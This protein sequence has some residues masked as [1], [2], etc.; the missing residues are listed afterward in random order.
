MRA[1]DGGRTQE[2][3]TLA[4]ISND[5]KILAG[6][7]QSAFLVA[8]QINREGETGKEPPKLAN[9]AGSDALGQ[10][11]DVVLTMRKEAHNVGTAFSVEGNRHGEEVK[12]YTTFDPNSGTF[13]EVDKDYLEELKLLAEERL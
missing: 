2:W 13:D 9:L 10:D 1:D 7:A 5:L 8:S 12:F 6:T 4:G 3:Q 11:G